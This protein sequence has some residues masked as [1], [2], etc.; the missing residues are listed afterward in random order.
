MLEYWQLSNENY[1]VKIKKDEGLDDECDFKNTP[2]A[3][4]GAFILSNCKGI[5]NSFI[6][7]I[8]GFD[9][10]NRYYSNTDSL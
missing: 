6:R 4:L 7:E 8:D 9:S 3:H 2:P 5:L 10:N 1:T